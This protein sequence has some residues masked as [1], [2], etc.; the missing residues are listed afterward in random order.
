MYILSN[1]KKNK[2]TYI[3]YYIMFFLVTKA[4]CVLSC[5]AVLNVEQDTSSIHGCNILSNLNVLLNAEV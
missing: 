2:Y 3:L 4:W 1:E 5:Q